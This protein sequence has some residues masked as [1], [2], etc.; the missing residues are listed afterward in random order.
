MYVMKTSILTLFMALFLISC[1]EGDSKKQRFV[2]DSSGNINNI[3]V[4][5]DNILWEDNVGE[6]IRNVLAA[7]LEGLPQD[8]P[9]FSISQMPSQ[10]FSGFTTKNRTVLKIEKGKP[11]STTIFKDVYAKPQTVIL[12]SG[13]T[14]AEIIDQLNTNAEKIVMTFKNSEIKE[15]QKRITLSLFDDKPLREDL[16]ISLKFPSVYRIAKKEDHFFWIRKDIK[17]G[18]MDFLAYQVPFSAIRKGDSAVIDI[19]RLRDSIGKKHVEGRLE[20]SYLATESAYAPYIFETI[21][22]NKPTFETKGIWD[23]KNDF[24]SGPFIN[25]AIEDKINNRYVIIEGYVFAPSVEKRDYVFEL[26]SIIRSLKID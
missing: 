10:V 16:G 18:T 24:M 5:V 19:V 15:K 6:A 22:D 8:E 25:Y 26:E 12:V 21:I 7:P 4:V 3:S 13:Q 9:I 20:G 11:A 14:N 23:L 17:T 2:S 1:N